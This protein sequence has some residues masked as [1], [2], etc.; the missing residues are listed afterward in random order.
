MLSELHMQRLC[1][2]AHAMSTQT[3]A[4]NAHRCNSLPHIA[5]L[6]GCRSENL[7]KRLNICLTC[8]DCGTHDICHITKV[9]G[10]KAGHPLP[11]I[12]KHDKRGSFRANIAANTTNDKVVRQGNNDATFHQQAGTN[13]SASQGATANNNAVQPRNRIGCT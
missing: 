2:L 12:S 11:T 8:H 1:S 7:H 9:T 6:I 3:T 4:A 13:T 5:S 10:T